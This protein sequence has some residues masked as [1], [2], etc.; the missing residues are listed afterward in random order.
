M[1]LARTANKELRALVYVVATI[2]ATALGSPSMAEL[3]ESHP[4]LATPRPKQ[5]EQ[6]AGRFALGPTTPIRASRADARTEGRL[7]AELLAT[8]TGL[9]L[10]LTDAMPEPVGVGAVNL[11]LVSEL[12]GIPAMGEKDE[13]YRIRIAPDGVWLE[14]RTSAGLYYAGQTLVDLLVPEGEGYSL[15]AGTLSDWPDFTWRGLWPASGSR[16][17]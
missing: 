5:W 1:L 14:A 17:W 2:L 8:A 15:P 10:A 16:S 7:L 12:A 6:T 13:G 9:N 3:N 11:S 4:P